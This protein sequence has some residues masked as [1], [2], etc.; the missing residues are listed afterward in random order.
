[1]PL[2]GFWVAAAIV[3][4]GHVLG[5]R[6]VWRWL[7]ER[8]PV[9]VQGLGLASLLTAALLLAPDASKAFVYFQF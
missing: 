6:A 2:A 1:L 3:A 9:P 5:H 7:L 8:V 4:V